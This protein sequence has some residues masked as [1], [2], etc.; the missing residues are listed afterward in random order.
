MTN[1][2]LDQIFGNKLFFVEHSFP[3][4]LLD[5]AITKKLSVFSV[6]TLR[7]HLCP[8]LSNPRI[9][10]HAW[11]YS[12]VYL[13]KPFLQFQIPNL[14]YEQ[15]TSYSARFTHYWID[16][17]SRCMRTNAEQEGVKMSSQIKHRLTLF[18]NPFPGFPPR[19]SPLT[20]KIIWR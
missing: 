15:L 20:S 6:G 9:Y 7:N 3:T 12:V 4:H 14:G 10:I 8:N 19:G 2:F 13:C 1:I 18:L 5:S 11:Y 16:F 17:W